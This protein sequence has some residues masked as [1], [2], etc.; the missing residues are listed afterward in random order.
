VNQSSSVA[1]TSLQ[2]EDVH[3]KMYLIGM[4]HV[5]TAES[6]ENLF[7][8]FILKLCIIDLVPPSC[9]ARELWCR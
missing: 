7:L 3:A 9:L 8:Y 6:Y 5:M 2:C 4:I 1:M